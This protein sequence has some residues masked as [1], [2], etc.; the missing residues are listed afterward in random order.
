MW[1]LKGVDGVLGGHARDG[2]WRLHRI[3]VGWLRTVALFVQIQVVVTSCIIMIPICVH[4]MW[5]VI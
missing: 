2:A 4:A 3:S 5:L 1:L